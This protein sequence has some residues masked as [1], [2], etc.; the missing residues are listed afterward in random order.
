MITLLHD[1]Q[2]RPGRIDKRSRTPENRYQLPG[3][4]WRYK[5]NELSTSSH[6]QVSESV[7]EAIGSYMTIFDAARGPRRQTAPVAVCAAEALT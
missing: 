5:C 2:A 6:W 4:D 1:D 7:I 3:P